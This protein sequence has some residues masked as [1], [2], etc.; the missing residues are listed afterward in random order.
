VSDG[1]TIGRTR[2]T[3]DVRGCLDCGTEWSHGWVPAR[4]VP[5]TIGT[6]ALAIGLSRCADC[7]VTVATSA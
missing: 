4:T 3:V 6:R 2:I 5:V 7:A 1:V